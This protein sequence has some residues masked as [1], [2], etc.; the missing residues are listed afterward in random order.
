MKNSYAQ[1][2]RLYEQQGLNADE[3]DNI[4][5]PDVKQQQYF[6]QYGYT[7]RHA[8]GNAFGCDSDIMGWL[9]GKH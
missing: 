9:F 7:D 5:V 2:Q 4:L 1:L 8:G 3:I 6:S